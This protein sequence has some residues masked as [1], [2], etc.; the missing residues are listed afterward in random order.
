MSR[1]R[2]SPSER[3][4]E[5]RHHLVQAMEYSSGDTTDPMVIDAICMRLSA[6]IDALTGLP[7]SLLADVFGGAWPLMRGMRNRIVHGY[8]LIDHDVI[9]A[10]VERDLPGIITAID[11]AALPTPQEHTDD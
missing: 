11:R 8:I 10:T 6:G 3:M 7:E 1:A 4:S 9:V 5:A 2:R